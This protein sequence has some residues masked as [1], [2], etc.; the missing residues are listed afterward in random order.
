MMAM[1]SLFG[2]K[3]VNSHCRELHQA[4]DSEE[5]DWDREN[6]PSDPLSLG[7]R[8]KTLYNYGK[9]NREIK[10]GVFDL[11]GTQWNRSSQ[12]EIRG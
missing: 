1:M 10:S 4:K 7:N 12:R 3:I 9:R 5:I 11:S 6:S 8:T 2:M